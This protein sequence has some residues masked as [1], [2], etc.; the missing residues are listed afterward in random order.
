MTGTEL[1]TTED[2]RYVA[3]TEDLA[4]GKV[5]ASPDDVPNG[6]G[7]MTNADFE[8][9]VEMIADAA[10]EEL[11]REEALKRAEVAADN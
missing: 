5:I 6:W 3:V 11:V 9:Q 7:L 8:Q 4:T 10:V 2:G 1:W